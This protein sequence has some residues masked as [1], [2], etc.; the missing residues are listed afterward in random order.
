MSVIRQQAID[1]ESCVAYYL[2]DLAKERAEQVQDWLRIHPEIAR[3]ARVDAEAQ[4][5]V[6]QYFERMFDEPIPPRLMTAG[7]YPGSR[8]TSRFAVAASIALAA[9]A[10]WWLGANPFMQQQPSVNALGNQEF[11]SVKPLDSRSQETVHTAD[12][13]VTTAHP[14]L[15]AEGYRFIGSKKLTRGGQPVSRFIYRDAQGQKLQIDAR[16]S[17]PA[18]AKTP[19]LYMDDGTMRVQWRRAGIRYS[20]VGDL[21]PASL[22][23]LAQAAAGKL[24]ASPNHV[25][26]SNTPSVEQSSPAP[27]QHDDSS[28]EMAADSLTSA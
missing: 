11:A 24:P 17:A 5:K 20:L 23:A 4:G 28:V 25:A 16:P 18:G 22:E 13:T 7:Q 21:P 1:Y 6:Q 10:G 8:W 26:G 3:R 12:T 9:T 14:D 15:T 27:E 2:G 19:D